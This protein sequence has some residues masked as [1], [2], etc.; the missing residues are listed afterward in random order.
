MHL[1]IE[2]V[3]FD[4]KE[5]TQEFVEHRLGKIDFAKDMIVDLEFTFVKETHEYELE[6]KVHFRWGNSHV[7]KVKSFELHEGIDTLID[8]LELKVKKEKD[9][10][11]EH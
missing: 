9:K 3:H 10:V 7:I 6:A 2:A 5:E 8:K 11:K 1:D 4:L